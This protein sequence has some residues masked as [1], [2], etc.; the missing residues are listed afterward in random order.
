MEMRPGRRPSLLSTILDKVAR[1]PSTGS[2]LAD[3]AISG[4]TPSESKLSYSTQEKCLY[5]TSVVV[6]PRLFCPTKVSSAASHLPTA[7][8]FMTWMWLLGLE[9]HQRA[10]YKLAADTARLRLP[11]NPYRLQN[12]ERRGHVVSIP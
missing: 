12:G 3:E 7:S 9:L 2:F 6:T 4:L 8:R 1:T 11:S 10:V 5:R